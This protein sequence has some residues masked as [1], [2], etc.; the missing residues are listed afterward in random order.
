MLDVTASPRMERILSR[1]AEIGRFHTG[2]PFVGTETV[3]RA[4]VEDRDGIAAQVLGELGVAERVAERL[5]DI[6][7]SDNYRT[8]ST[9]VSPTPRT[10]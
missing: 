1:A 10:D 5:D 3:L 6:M 9:K 8:H 4:L 2:A 7:S